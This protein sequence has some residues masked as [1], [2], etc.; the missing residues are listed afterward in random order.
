[1]VLFLRT[2]VRLLRMLCEAAHFNAVL[3]RLHLMI[4]SIS[5]LIPCMANIVSIIL[6]KMLQYFSTLL[7]QNKTIVSCLSQRNT[8]RLCSRSFVRSI[9]LAVL[10]M[11][12]R[13][14]F[15]TN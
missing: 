1:M 3:T 11:F 8:S 2:A 4:P 6:N 12:E 14:M 5:I 10:I 7:V 15:E 13:R 9:F